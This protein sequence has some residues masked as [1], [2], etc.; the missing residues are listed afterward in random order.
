MADDDTEEVRHLL[1]SWYLELA[2]G[3]EAG[4]SGPSLIAWPE[5]SQGHSLLHHSSVSVTLDDDNFICLG[6]RVNIQLF[7]TTPG[8]L[9]VSRTTK[10]SS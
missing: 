9:I 4:S 1:C 10:R 5:T 3:A 6:I 8:A 2:L 7:L